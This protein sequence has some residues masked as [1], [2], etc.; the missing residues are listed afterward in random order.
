MFEHRMV[1]DGRRGLIFVLFWVNVDDYPGH[2]QNP[3]QDTR[4]ILLAKL[5][6]RP[7]VI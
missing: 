5:S 4:K 3:N 1:I 2:L 7:D 6:S